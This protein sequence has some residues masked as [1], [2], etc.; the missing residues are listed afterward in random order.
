M[1]VVLLAIGAVVAV[2]GLIV[3]GHYGP[4]SNG[5]PKPIVVC[6]ANLVGNNSSLGGS[7]IVDFSLSGTPGQFD[8]LLIQLQT[9]VSAS[10]FI[11]FVGIDT[12]S[13]S[14]VGETYPALNGT[15]EAVLAPVGTLT[16]DIS[17]NPTVTL[18]RGVAF[19]VTLTITDEGTV[20]TK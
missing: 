13:G 4:P 16:A 3:F 15:G 8:A 12:V 2:S 18:V 17:V 9:N 11:G 6:S 1:V 14:V 10:L 7:R 20:I 19:S 5:E